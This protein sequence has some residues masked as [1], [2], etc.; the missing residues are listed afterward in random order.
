MTPPAD[1]SARLLRWFDQHGRHDLPW[2]HPRNAYRVW[3]AE[4]MLQQTQV[5]T[6]IPYY[7]GFL[8]IFPDL[9]ALAS[10]T[11]DEV[12]GRWSGLGYYSRARNLHAAA[13]RCMALHKGELPTDITMLMELPGIGRSTAAAILAQAHGQAQAILDGNV[14]RLLCRLFAI[15]GWPGA[16]SVEKVLWPLAQSLLPE[17]GEHAR[18]ADY[19]QAIM[20]FGASQCRRS[21]PDCAKCPFES[22]CAAR[23]FNR[24]SELPHVRP[25]KVLLQRECVMLLL[26]A[27]DGRFLLHRRP[28]VGVWASLWSLP[29]FEDID[30]AHRWART[31]GV[32]E[33]SLAPMPVIE[34]V[35][36]HFRLAIQPLHAPFESTSNR[37]A[38]TD[39]SRWLSAL[40]LKSLGLPAPVRRLIDS[41]TQAPQTNPLPSS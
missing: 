2:Q 11:E 34:H 36:S 24:V 22:D 3:V 5:T 29:Q 40:E 13:K 4:I 14:K 32:A 26:A 21:R 7:Q 8:D 31:F 39:D 15:D 37:V 6:V 9:P 30:S 18:L 1:F 41:I 38:D 12:L 25:S 33:P 28:P 20:D 17:A 27:N 35:F 23:R 19:T 16:A 10:A